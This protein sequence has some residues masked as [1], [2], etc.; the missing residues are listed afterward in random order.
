MLHPSPRAPRTAAIVAR[1]IRQAFDE[2]EVACV[3]EPG[4]GL[5]DV[6]LSLPFDHIFFTG[7][8][9]VGQGDGGGRRHAGVR[10]A[11]AGGKVTACRR[12]FGE[13][14][15]RRP[16]ALSG[17]SS[18]TPARRVSLPTIAGARGCAEAVRGGRRH[19]IVRRYG[20][21]EQARQGSQDLPRVVDD[22]A[23]RR[24]QSL[25]EASSPKGRPRRSEGLPTRPSATSRRRSRPAVD[26]DSTIMRDEIFG[27]ILP[28]L[29]FRHS[30]T[31]QRGS[32]CSASRSRCTSSADA[33]RTWNRCSPRRRRGLSS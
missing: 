4:D 14:R 1:I 16:S 17:A 32:T 33:R 7:S 8:A 19:T 12:R 18:S 26:W 9:R 25:L 5:A 20:A 21:T 13:P 27:P 11:R 31:S 15:A 2:A 22:A 30:T 28:V 3:A 23:F 6:L 29:P 24:L 10:D